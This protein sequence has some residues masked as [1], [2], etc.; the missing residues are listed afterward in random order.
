MDLTGVFLNGML[1]GAIARRRGFDLV[2]FAILAIVSALGGGM[3][4]DTL[5]QAGPPLA[6]VDPLYLGA[7]LIGALVAFV[8]RLERQW[9]NRV[10]IVGDALVLGVWAATGASKALVAGLGVLPAVMLGVTTAV[11]G[12]IIR[13][14]VVGQ[15]PAVFGGNTLYATSAVFASLAMVALFEQGHET[16]GMVAAI[17]VGAGL[18]IIARWRRWTLPAAD[19]VRFA[20]PWLPVRG[21]GAARRDAPGPREPRR[22]RRVPGEPR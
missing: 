19:D 4:R 5:L 6:L 8:V 1:G 15:V 11:G 17:V 7:A 9:W 16:L 22:R 12:G 20:A 3:L 10:F 21:R 13:D 14:V 18:S 2:G